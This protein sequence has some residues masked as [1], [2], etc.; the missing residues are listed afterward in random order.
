MVNKLL[1]TYLGRIPYDNRDS[2][3]NKKIESSGE[4]DLLVQSPPS[5]KL[6]LV[7]PHSL[8]RRQYISSIK[9]LNLAGVILRPLQSSGTSL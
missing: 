8:F 5:R 6:A 9:G 7:M 3:L 1:N 2:F 4:L